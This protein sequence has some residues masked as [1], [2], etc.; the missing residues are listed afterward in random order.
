MMVKINDSVNQSLSSV[1]TKGLKGLTEDRTIRL[2]DLAMYSR[3]SVHSIYW[4][5]SG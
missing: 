1:K 4:S 3:P 5:R 2:A